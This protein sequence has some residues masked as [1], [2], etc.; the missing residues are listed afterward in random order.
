MRD[1]SRNACG[2]TPYQK[3]FVSQK[4]PRWCSFSDRKPAV[5]PSAMQRAH[6]GGTSPLLGRNRWFGPAAEKNAIPPSNK[7]GVNVFAS[8]FKKQNI[9]DFSDPL[10]ETPGEDW[11][12]RSGDRLTSDVVNMVCS[13]S[14]MVWDFRGKI[15]PLQSRRNRC[16]LGCKVLR[17]KKM[18]SHLNHS[19]MQLLLF[20]IIIIIFSIMQLQTGNPPFNSAGASIDAR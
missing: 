15:Q 5:G 14:K 13:G 6:G 8:I 20:N 19:I 3:M 17:E 11:C 2:C 12:G 16:K 9:L 1:S 7:Q 10:R 4:K 18:C